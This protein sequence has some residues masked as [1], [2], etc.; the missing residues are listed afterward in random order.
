LVGDEP[1]DNPSES[2]GL[3]VKVE[4]GHLLGRDVGAQGV[5]PQAHARAEHV[6]EAEVIRRAVHDYLDRTWAS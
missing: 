6:A 4:R 3:P 1:S 2:A 5:D